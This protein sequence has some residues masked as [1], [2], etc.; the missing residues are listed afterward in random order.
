MQPACELF[1]GCANVSAAWFSAIRWPRTGKPTRIARQSAEVAVR[2]IRPPLKRIRD[3][4]PRLDARHMVLSVRMCRR[5]RWIRIRRL[6]CYPRCKYIPFVLRN[7][8]SSKIDFPACNHPEANLLQPFHNLR[9]RYPSSM[10]F[11]SVP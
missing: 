3:A 5:V 2:N 8:D 9:R 1:C 4:E 6:L 10:I 11:V 7:P